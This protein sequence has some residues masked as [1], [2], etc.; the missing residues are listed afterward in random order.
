MGV[1]KGFRPD[2]RVL[3]PAQ[4]CLKSGRPECDAW[5]RSLAVHPLNSGVPDDVIPKLKT[6]CEQQNDADACAGFARLVSDP[7][8]PGWRLESLPAWI[9]ACDLGQ[10]DA[11]EEVADRYHRQEPPHSDLGRQFEQR[12]CELGSGVAC[13]E[14]GYSLTNARGG[15]KDAAAA[16]SAYSRACDAGDGMG[17][18][19]L[20]ANYQDGE[21]VAKDSARAL[22]LF[23]FACDAGVALGC[24]NLKK[25]GGSP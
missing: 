2:A 16:F 8:S 1:V 22:P 25:Y 23:A 11:C 24:E 13:T 18:N 17:C 20:G 10:G 21:A 5:G 9:H 7:L 12:G 3:T 14:W 15:A 19:N 6:L 4:R